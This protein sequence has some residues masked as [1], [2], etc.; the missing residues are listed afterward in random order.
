M[1]RQVKTEWIGNL[2]FESQVDGRKITI[3]AH[4]E[5]GGEDRGPSPEALLLTSLTS[6]TGMDIV[7]LLQKMRVN[8]ENFRI[9]A[10]GVLT[11]THP[12]HY[13]AIHLVFEFGGIHLRREKI[14]EAV[15]LS[16]ER[17]C[18]ISHMLSKIAE[19]T[20]DVVF[21]EKNIPVLQ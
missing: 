1:E 9:S 17:Y 11:N 6:C 15:N 16:L 4:P 8:V 10:T 19:V 21:S 14:N 18:G 7:S 12:K 5:F 20:Y 13:G 3:D 2:S